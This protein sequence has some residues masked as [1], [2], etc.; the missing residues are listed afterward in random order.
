MIKGEF[1]KDQ[2]VIRDLD[3]LEFRAVIVN[4][5]KSVQ[6]ADIRYEEDDVVETHVPLTELRYTILISWCNIKLTACLRIAT[7]DDQNLN[8]TIPKQPEVKESLL[9]PANDYDP[10]KKPKVVIH[11]RGEVTSGT[12]IVLACVLYSKYEL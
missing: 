7:E 3:G 10:T 6:E 1:K 5:Y 2:N 12:S 9:L 11:T 8:S 4:L